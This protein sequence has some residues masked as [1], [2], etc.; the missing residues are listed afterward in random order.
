MNNKFNIGDEVVVI[1]GGFQSCVCDNESTLP[2]S[3]QIDMKAFIKD[4]KIND[5]IIW[6][7]LFFI[8]LNYLYGN[9]ISEPGLALVNKGKIIDLTDINN[10]LKEL[11][12]TI[13]I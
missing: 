1:D 9:W 3:Y 7:E 13:K 2:S 5:N 4:I 11:D 8:D 10:F 12:E 6:Y